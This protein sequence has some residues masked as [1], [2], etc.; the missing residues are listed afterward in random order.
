MGGRC[1]STSGGIAV[2]CKL[3]DGNFKEDFGY[4]RWRDARDGK[5]DLNGG[6]TEAVLGCEAALRCLCP[7]RPIKALS[8]APSSV[9]SSNKMTGA[10]RYSLAGVENRP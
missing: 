4:R 5:V 3:N 1:T 10:S 9:S 2:S 7:A 6:V 8:W